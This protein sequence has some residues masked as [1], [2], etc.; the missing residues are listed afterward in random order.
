VTDLG[1][2]YALWLEMTFEVVRGRR[3]AAIAIA[4]LAIRSIAEWFRLPAVARGTLWAEDARRFLNSASIVGPANA[5]AVPYAGY[6]HTI[7]RL[8]AGFAVQFTPVS[9]WADV[10]SG[11]SCVVAAGVAALV[12]VCSRDIVQ[13]IVPRILLASITL[14]DPLSPHEVLGNAANLHWYFLWL[15]PWL[16]LYRPRSRTGA[17]A[18]GLVALLA[19]LTEIQLVF[20]MP[21]LAWRM[22]DRRRWPVRIP[23]AVGVLTQLIVTLADPRGTGPHTVIGLPSLAA[24]FLVNAVLPIVFPTSQAVGWTFAHGGPLI[25]I[26]LLLLLLAIAGWGFMHS[27][28]PARRLFVALPLASMGLYAAA[29][30]ATPTGFSDYAASSAA[31]WA[32]PWI[33]RYG[34][35]PSMLLL[36]VI[37]VALGVLGPATRTARRILWAGSVVLVVLLLAQFIPSSTRR[38]GGPLWSPQVS[39]ATLLCESRPPTTFVPLAGAPGGTWLVHV[40]CARLL[41]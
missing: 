31:H 9:S 37:P 24:G 21:L 19:S 15:S 32:T 25:G 4:I 6:L 12:F 23:F 17:W 39:R 33:D 14:L 38:D 13:P 35:V 34:V 10:M 27:H 2:R 18:L 20:A 22:R 7:P 36:A 41:G 8:I 40:Q 5:L 28:G 26:V 29:V 30:E 11:A 16:L 3:T 1:Q